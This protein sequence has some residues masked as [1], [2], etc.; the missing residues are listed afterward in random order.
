MLLH[1]RLC[2]F[3]L[4]VAN[5]VAAENDR[6]VQQLLQLYN[7]CGIFMRKR[8]RGGFLKW[9]KF[10]ETT[11]IGILGA[12]VSGTRGAPHTKGPENVVLDL[13]I[14]AKPSKTLLGQVPSLLVYP[15]GRLYR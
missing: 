3:L 1:R 7:G 14:M 13:V 12:L 11:K 5:G 4:R 9:H 6:T 8:R 10:S 15:Q 2:S